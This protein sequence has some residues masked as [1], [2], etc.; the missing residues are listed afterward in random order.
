MITAFVLSLVLSL[1]EGAG[2]VNITSK[3]DFIQFVNDVNNE[4]STYSGTTVFLDADISLSGES[5]EPIGKGSNSCFRGTFDGQGHVISGLRISSSSQ[6][7]GLFGYSDGLIIKNL[8]LDGTCSVTSTPSSTSSNAGSVIGGCNG[9]FMITNVV[10]MGS[11]NFT[12]SGSGTLYLGGIAGS[13]SILQSN[14]EVYNCI[15]YGSVTHS[16]GVSSESY[17]GG[18]IGNGI[19]KNIEVGETI[20]VTNNAN[21]GTI[22]YPSS[23]SNGYIGGIIGAS[24]FVTL[25]NCLSSGRIEKGGC[26]YVGGILGAWNGNN[27]I[28]NCYWTDETGTDKSDGDGTAVFDDTYKINQIN[29]T[30]KVVLNSYTTDPSFDKWILLNL[31]GGNI[32]GMSQGMLAVMGRH[33]PVPLK[34]GHTFMYWCEDANCNV[35][36]NP[37]STNL[38]DVDVLTAKWGENVIVTFSSEETGFTQSKQLVCGMPYGDLPEENRRGYTFLGWFTEKD[39][40]DKIEPSETVTK[41]TEHTLYAHWEANNYTV[42]FNATGGNLAGPDKVNAT[43]GSKYD[44]LPTP[45]REG[46]IFA[47]WLTENN[48][49]VT[50]GSTVNISDD[51]TLYAQWAPN[52]YTV[53]FNP[54]GGIV[55]PTSVNVTFD[56]AYGDLLTDPS[57]TG[58]TFAGW[59][60]EE[61]K[62]I[63]SE[64]IVETPNDHTL[65]AQ[66][67]PNNYTVSFDVNGGDELDTKEINV[68]F[69]KTYGDLPTPNREGFAFLGWLTENNEE[70]TSGTTVNITNNHTLYAKWTINKYTISF[71]FNGGDKCP[72]IMGNYNTSFTLPKPNRTGYTFV[73]WCSDFSLTTEYTNRKIEPRNVTLFAKWTPNIY[74]VSFDATGGDLLD[75]N[76]VNVTFDS[77][78]GELPIPTKDNYTFAGWLTEN[79]ESV[80]S[81]STVNIPYDHTLYAQW[82]PNNYTLTFVFLNG[83]IK[84][85]IYAF[86]EEIR[87]P[88]NLVKE[89][90]NFIEWVPKPEYMPAE[91]ITV[92]AKWNYIGTGTE[93]IEINFNSKDLTGEEIEKIIKKYT[94]DSFRIEKINAFEEETFV[95]IKF[96][97]ASSAMN[98]IETISSSS[99]ADAIFKDAK[100]VD[101]RLFISLSPITA[102]FASHLLLLL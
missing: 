47:G 49:E 64:S 39:R 16:D 51:H 52:T 38:E 102:T 66:W 11:V 29:S 24:S 98:F 33:F 63:T 4:G 101:G 93:Y 1:G 67:S 18:I 48:E 44:V 36:Y 99:D 82:A 35:K 100:F 57:R 92:R 28:T 6:Y 43:F 68:T 41:T 65:H 31:T 79:N 5:V 73:H 95:I 25:K 3:N 77:N 50:S 59:F 2:T 61:N 72:V 69:D 71:E 37:I 30:T 23:Q 21:Y 15:N 96:E 7:V 42:T 70:I 87:Y 13:L 10:N 86:N 81:E 22:T 45:N 94:D 89:D 9:D 80:T 62:R 74:A 78:Y 83:T 17:I 76:D 75:A 19:G 40:G 91:N 32:N 14:S 34:E 97:D 46:F 58:Y 60:T 53:T 84:K 88:K 90:F 8:V 85:E 20:N 27:A 26:N 56:T 55:T 54:K 12:G